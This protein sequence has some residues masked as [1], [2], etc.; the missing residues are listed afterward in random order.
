MLYLLSYFYPRIYLLFLFYFVL[1]KSF[2]DFSN[3]VRIFSMKSYL[4]KHFFLT[5][6]FGWLNL[7]ESFSVSDLFTETSLCLIFILVFL[8]LEEYFNIF[9]WLSGIKELDFCV[10]SWKLFQ[11]GRKLSYF[12]L[13]IEIFLVQIS[14]S[15]FF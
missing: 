14:K 4:S 1:S 9:S 5:K 8:T 3:V 6:S 15:F 12:F 7:L 11:I 10:W 13:C 2:M